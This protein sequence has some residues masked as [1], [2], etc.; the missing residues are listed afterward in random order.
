MMNTN[1]FLLG[2]LVATIAIVSVQITNQLQIQELIEKVE[3]I[4]Q[5]AAVVTALDTKIFTA[6]SVPTPIENTCVTTE[7]KELYGVNTSISP[8]RSISI[9]VLCDKIQPKS[10]EFILVTKNKEMLTN[11]Y[12]KEK[13][14][15]KTF[16]VT[17]GT[18]ENI[19]SDT[20]E[21]ILAKGSITLGAT[22]WNKSTTHTFSLSN[23][24]NTVTA[25]PYSFN[26]TTATSTPL[27]ILYGGYN[28]SNANPV[29]LFSW[30]RC[31]SQYISDYINDGVT[32]H[33]YNCNPNSSA[34]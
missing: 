22:T 5:Q 9:K 34:F 4:P 6:T 17:I 27:N 10:I 26:L 8:T 30:L 21:L 25:I 2:G 13:E 29:S 24:E 14:S 28:N 18:Q 7:T 20:G 1:K 12:M 23:A 19:G 33:N 11:I 3:T 31:Q 32:L 16:L 15:N